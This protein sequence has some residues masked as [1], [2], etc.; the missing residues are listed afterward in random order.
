M[1]TRKCLT[2]YSACLLTAMMGL[3]LNVPTA[4][5]ETYVYP[6]KKQSKEQQT[7]DQGE[8][9]EWAIQKSGVDPAKLAAQSSS[10]EVYQKHH[11]A[12]GGASRGALLGVVGGAIGGHAG[13][14]AAIGAG[15]GALAGGMRNRQDLDTQHQVYANA[16]AEQKGQLKQYDNAYSACLTGR[17]YTVK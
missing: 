16:H 2:L 17:G 5:A 10:G 15:V 6:A 11:S 4:E 1:N 14:G 13:E 8:C 3:S 12:L 9:H 7:K